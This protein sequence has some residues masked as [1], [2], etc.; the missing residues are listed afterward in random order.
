MTNN[1]LEGLKFVDLKDYRVLYEKVYEI[2]DR[3]PLSKTDCGKL[4]GKI[5]C[6]YI[7]PEEEE[8]GMELLPG[9]EEIFPLEADWLKP[10][11]L[12]GAMYEY[13]P[14]WGQHAGCFQIRCIKPCP[15]H[16]RPVNCRLFPLKFFREKENY[17]LILAKDTES[18]NCPL[19]ERPELINPEFIDS[20]KKAASLLLSIPKFRQLVDWDS[21]AIIPDDVTVRFPIAAG[22][23]AAGI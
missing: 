3:F 6:C 19:L 2:L 23:L 4:C 15:R 21:A 18:Y 14:E 1:I 8:A 11:F 17:Y 20:A 13:P 12:S 22:I 5:C 7:V 16:E 9:E 10:R